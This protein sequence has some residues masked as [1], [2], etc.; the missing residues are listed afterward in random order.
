MEE[1]IVLFDEEFAEWLQ[2]DQR[3]KRH[4]ESLENEGG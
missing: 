3:F 2:A 1:W 4:L